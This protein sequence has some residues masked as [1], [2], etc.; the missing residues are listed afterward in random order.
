MPSLAVV[1]RNAST[2]FIAA[3]LG[4]SGTAV[5][6][7][8][9]ASAAGLVLEAAPFVVAATLG[10]QI[11]QRIERKSPSVPLSR[12]TTVFFGLAGCGCLGAVG[13]LSL[14]SLA[15]TSY[16]FGPAVAAIRLTGALVLAL[17]P[18]G[19][20]GDDDAHESAPLDALAALVPYALCGSVAAQ[21]LLALQSASHL[22]RITAFV[23][24][25]VVGLLSPCAL[26]ALAVAASLR[27]AA[28]SAAL[29]ILATAGFIAMRALP[30]IRVGGSAL[31]GST[32]WAA[33]LFLVAVV[34]V[35]VRGGAG[36]V[37]PRLITPSI[38]AASYLF[39]HALVRQCRSVSFFAPCAIA[40]ALIVG[41]PVPRYDGD[42]TALDAAFAGQTVHFTGVVRRR[43]SLCL[44]I[45]FTITCCRADA[46]PL[47]LR[48]DHDVG[49]PDGAWV[50]ADGVFAESPSGL[51]LRTTRIRAVAAPAD[52][53]LYR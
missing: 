50:S 51:V 28:P 32:L 16:A 53:F 10:K 15:L 48:L 5:A 3:V 13:A 35:A 6:Q 44:L 20:R 4:C 46:T 30:L 18:L 27:A 25:A 11:L 36:L 52:P 21:A 23:A 22:S 45:R 40:V 19:Q 43:Q 12:W 14:S 2:L 37:H 26:G 42:A 8:A 9:L 39:V 33:A 49:F 34:L 29:G 7:A 41:S 38:V 24:G 47:S 17:L 31:R 1:R